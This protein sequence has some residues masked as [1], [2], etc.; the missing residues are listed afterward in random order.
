MDILKHIRKAG[1]DKLA[2]QSRAIK[3]QKNRGVYTV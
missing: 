1:V 3:L 2:D